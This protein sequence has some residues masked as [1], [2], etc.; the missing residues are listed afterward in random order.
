MVLY[1]DQPRDTA[2]WEEC[3]DLDEKSL[4]TFCRYDGRVKGIAR[5]HQHEFYET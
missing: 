4:T 5:E 2:R 3:L 1:S